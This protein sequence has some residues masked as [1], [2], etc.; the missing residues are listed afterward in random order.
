MCSE[1]GGNGQMPLLFVYKSPDSLLYIR[2]YKVEYL[3]DSQIAEPI[4]PAKVLTIS[5]DLSQKIFEKRF[6][7]SEITGQSF[8][9][10]S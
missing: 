7:C 4:K 2:R 1:A 9:I 5:Y 3:Q 6:H 8:R 10:Q